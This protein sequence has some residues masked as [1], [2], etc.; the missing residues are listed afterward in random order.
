MPKSRIWAPRF[1]RPN[2]RYGRPQKCL[3]II[4]GRFEI[5]LASFWDVAG[6]THKLK[7]IRNLQYLF[8]CLPWSYKGTWKEPLNAEGNTHNGA[9]TPPYGNSLYIIYGA[10]RNPRI[11][12]SSTPTPWGHQACGMCS[13]LPSC[14]P[15]SGP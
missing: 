10:C 12:N 13:A 1:G 14:C 5:V 15:P 6:N 3:G 2:H 8:R 9:S 11:K 7:N 4:L